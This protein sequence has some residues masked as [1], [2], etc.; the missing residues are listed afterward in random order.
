MRENKPFAPKASCHHQFVFN[1]RKVKK[2]PDFLLKDQRP[3][4]KIPYLCSNNAKN[5]ERIILESKLR[6]DLDL[7]YSEMYS[8]KI[9]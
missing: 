7:A 9:E 1:L 2:R 3:I 6:E 4:S 5:Q 8:G